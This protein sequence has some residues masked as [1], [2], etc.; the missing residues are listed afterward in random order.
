VTDQ[1]GPDEPMNE[2]APASVCIMG[3]NEGSPAEAAGLKQY[4]FIT[5]VNGERVTSR[6]ELTTL[7]DTFKPGDT[8]TLTI[9][10]YNNVG[11]MNNNNYDSYYSNP[12]GFGFGFPFGGYSYGYG[13]NGNGNNGN[14]SDYY[15]TNGTVT[16]GGGFST[17]D[18]QVTLE[19]KQ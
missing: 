2:Y 17:F 6:R 18:V 13:N 12:F 16:V 8:V 19:E 14:G 1:D 15:Y 7:L 10:R 3:V 9:V 11:M 4:D 5:A